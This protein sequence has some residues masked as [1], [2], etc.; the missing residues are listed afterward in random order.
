VCEIEMLEE[1]R[2]VKS[3]MCFRTFSLLT[4]M[5]N[6]QSKTSC[7][8]RNKKALILAQIFVV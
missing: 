6:G 2:V 5:E 4:T 8:T 7:K 1:K 3:V